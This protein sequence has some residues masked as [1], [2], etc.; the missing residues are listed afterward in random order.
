MAMIEARII[1]AHIIRKYDI[2][3]NPKLSKVNW[4]SR[5]IQTYLPDDAIHLQKLE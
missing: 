1:L 4:L 3:K 2:I 5:G